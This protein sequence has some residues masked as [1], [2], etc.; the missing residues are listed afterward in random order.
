V[1]FAEFATLGAT[2]GLLAG[3]GAAGIGWALGRFAFQLAYLP[4]PW[5]PITGLVAGVVGVV[6]AGLWATRDAVK[7]PVSAQ[8]LA[9]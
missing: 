8:L 4:S 1:L 3:A 2:A 7:K 6:A 5:L 9:G